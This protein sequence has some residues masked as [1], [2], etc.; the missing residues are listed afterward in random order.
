MDFVFCE[1]QTEFT[2][3]IHRDLRFKYVNDLQMNVFAPAN[4]IYKL[5]CTK[6]QNAQHKKG[7]HTILILMM[8]C[9]VDI[10]LILSN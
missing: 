4:S 9:S 5:E 7:L 8:S 3:L 2:C 6:T 10:L 1:A